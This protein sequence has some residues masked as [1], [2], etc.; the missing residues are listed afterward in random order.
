MNDTLQDRIE[1]ARECQRQ[2]TDRDLN[3]VAS[4]RAHSQVRTLATDG[5]FALSLVEQCFQIKART[6]RPTRAQI[7]QRRDIR[8]IFK[9]SSRR[10]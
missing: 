9:A 8:D 7:E 2:S 4:L 6:I 3:L 5:G 1:L 10:R